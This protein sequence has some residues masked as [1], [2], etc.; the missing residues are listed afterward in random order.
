MKPILA[1]LIACCLFLVAACDPAAFSV[2]VLRPTSGTGTA[3]ANADGSSA[4]GEISKVL[5]GLGFET[6]IY[7]DDSVSPGL[8]KKMTAECG[9]PNYWVKTSRDNVGSFGN[10]VRVCASGKI[11]RVILSDFGRFELSEPTKVLRA[12]LIKALGERLPA[13]EV[14]VE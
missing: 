9:H 12:T 7:P 3:L 10:L 5:E 1:R 13:M 11:V 2:L 8:Q 4:V 14:S 6:R